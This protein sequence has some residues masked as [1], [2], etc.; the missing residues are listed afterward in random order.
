MSYRFWVFI[1]ALMGLGVVFAGFAG[2]HMGLVRDPLAQ[3]IYDTALR[4]HVLHVAALLAIAWLVS[5]DRYRAGR[6]G[7]FAQLAGVAFVFGTVLFAGGLYFQA[8]R[9]FAPGASIVP[10]GG[11]SLMVGWGLMALC[12]FGLPGM[13]SRRREGE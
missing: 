9:G 2:W 8:I 13:S 11:L 1:A 7:W 6:T 5:L 4:Y 10:A 3:A 12:A